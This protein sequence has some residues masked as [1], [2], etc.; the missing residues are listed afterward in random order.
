[1]T[2]LGAGATAPA[3]AQVSPSEKASG[4]EGAARAG[5]EG[6]PVVDLYCHIAPELFS[7]EMARIAP[8]LGNIAARLRSVRPLHD[9]DLRFRGMDAFG[10]YR[11]VISL[12]NPP[13]EDFADERV[14]IELARIG[15]DAMAEL[16]R[17]HP[18]RFAAFVAAVCLTDVD[19]SAAEAR[20]AVTEL[21]AS[22]VQIF[23]NIAGRP[24]DRPEFVP[25][26]SAMA[27]LDRPIWLHPARTAASSDYA[28]EPNSRYEMWWCFGWPYETSVAMS[29]LVFCGLF[30]RH[31]NLKIVTHHC[32]GMIPFYDGRIGPGMQVLGSRTSDEDYSKVLSTL[33]RPHLDYFRDF[34]ADTAMFGGQYGVGCGLQFFGS[35]KIVFATDTPLGPIGPTIAA[36]NKLG[37]DPQT[38]RKIYCGNAERLLKVKFG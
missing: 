14:G 17:K 2:G 8:K 27:D 28:A 22:G 31:P 37:L 1:M 23:T 36:I 35:D 25:F 20:R 3:S 6:Y 9:L 33:K 26:F 11:Q 16:V 5:H 7:T 13:I 4:G 24:L 38:R 10:D 21:G 34:Y 30:D 12:P 15:N 32:G 29:R 19:A 18:S